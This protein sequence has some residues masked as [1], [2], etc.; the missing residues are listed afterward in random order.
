[1]PPPVAESGDSA[2]WAPPLDRTVSLRVAGL[3]LREALDE[4]AVAGNLRLSYSDELLPLE[5]EVCLAAE[6]APAGRVFL[7]LLHGTNLSA[8][9]LGGDQVVLAP[10]MPA[11]APAP[12]PL[13]PP[14]PDMAS[15]LDILDRVVVTS[16]AAAVPRA[17]TPVAMD[18]IDGRRLERENTSTLSE[19]LD[20][21]S[22]GVWGWAQSP[23]SLLS[24]YASIRGASSFGLSYPKIYIDGIEVANPLIVTRFDPASIDRIEVIR[25]P[26]GSALYGADAISGVINVVTRQDPPD[27]GGV[28]ASLRSSAGMSQSAF[29]HDVLAQSHSASIA[30]GSAT[31]SADLRVSGETLGSFVPNGFSRDLMLSG[32]A[33]DVGEHGSLAATARFFTQQSGAA[34]SP[35]LPLSGTLPGDS[36]PGSTQASA[37]QSVSEYT[38]GMKGVLDGGDGWTHTF[39]A[40]V[41][42]Y[43]LSNATLSYS[44]LHTAADSALLAAEGSADRATLRATSQR[45]VGG[46]DRA[47]ADLTFSAEHSTLRETSL[48]GPEYVP[49]GRSSGSIAAAQPIEAWQNSTGL[50]AQTTGTFANALFGTAGLRVEQ[51]SRLNAWSALA[52]LPMLGGSAVTERDGF[53]LKVRAA[54]GKGIRPPSA[55]TNT[56]VGPGSTTGGAQALQAAARAALGPE[57]QAGVEAGIDLSYKSAVAFH[58]TRF[59]QRA[60]GLIQD[61]AVP[62][63]MRTSQQRSMIFAPENVGEISNSGW[64]LAA[65]TGVSRLTATG[66]LSFVDSHVLKLAPGYTGDLETGDRMLQ[67]PARTASLNATWTESRWRASLGASRALDWINYDEVALTQALSQAELDPRT[68]PLAAQLRS[69]WREYNGGLRLRAAATHDIGSDLEFDISAENLLNYQRGEPDNITVVPGRTILTGLR[70]KF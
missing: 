58:V 70:L 8:I 40:G 47:N 65:S 7:E 51:D 46:N 32:G 21:N 17:A 35:F 26:Q 67:V 11:A 25:G 53:A 69:Y 39:I 29:A 45:H 50:T 27:D 48:G 56:I 28:H 57:E 2:H 36:T 5:H 12:T 62:N 10:Q 33:R 1:M 52:L 60:S 64:E 14:T 3:P 38:V 16:T 31:R 41:D 22:P 6:K 24:S 30:A 54:Y 20:A 13:R 49:N 61:V 55:L 59:D 23:A 68:A 9:G 34:N 18:V 66:A 63:F 37:P 4:L 44:P 19:A 42:G 43:R 15:S